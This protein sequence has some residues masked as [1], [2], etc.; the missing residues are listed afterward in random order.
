MSE[1]QIFRNAEFGAVR[2]VDVNGDPWFVA[3][4]V[5]RALGYPEK[6]PFVNSTTF[7]GMSRM[8]GR[9]VIGL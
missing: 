9:V 6:V 7:S 5:A 8:N 1:M 4:D 2:V 3:K